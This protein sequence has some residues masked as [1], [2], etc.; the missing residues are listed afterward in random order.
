MTAPPAVPDAFALGLEFMRRP[1]RP[2]T[3]DGAVS[4][5][6]FDLVIDG[7]M[8]LDPKGSLFHG[9]PNARTAADQLAL[10]FMYC[11]V[12]IC[13]SGNCVR[14]RDESGVEIHR[15]PIDYT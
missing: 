14:V 1:L 6:F 5:F 4:R 3:A 12:E 7:K 13:S 9:S 8:L 15:S 2:H 10:H 11:R